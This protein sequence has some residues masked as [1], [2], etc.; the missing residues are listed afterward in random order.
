MKDE[1][2]LTSLGARRMLDW[3]QYCLSIG[4]KKSQL[5]G[6]QKIWMEHKDENGNLKTRNL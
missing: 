5:K 3:L 6:L 1:K 4:W 2:P